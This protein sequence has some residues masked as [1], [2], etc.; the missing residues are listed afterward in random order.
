MLNPATAALILALVLVILGPLTSPLERRFFQSNPS[1]RRKLAY[2]TINIALSWGL[3]VAAIAIYGWPSLGDSGAWTDWLPF[4]AIARPVLGAIV[5]GY[6]ALSLAPFVQSLRSA[7]RRG[8]YA[9]AYR[10]HAAEFPAILPAN[11]VE[12]ATFVLVALTAGVCEE[13][14]FR[15]FLIR[16]LHDGAPALPLA[17]A[18]VVSSLVF[19]LNHLYQGR[20]GVLGTTIAGLGFGLLFLVTGSLIPAI[21][22]HA[23]VD[24]QMVYVLRP[25]PADALEATA[26]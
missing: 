9:A 15:G 26:T 6:F 17:A 10:R 25:V 20:K 14:L 8:A 5:A 16:F 3:A 4:P 1:T 24:L 22:I 18:L 19:G 21:I 11:A 2:Y 7:H 13:V 23:L 12:R